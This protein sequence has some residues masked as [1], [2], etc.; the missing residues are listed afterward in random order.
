MSNIERNNVLLTCAGRRNYLVEFFK[1]ALDGKGKVVCTDCSLQAPAMAEADVA[2]KV[3]RVYEKNYV[4]TIL[5]ICKDN[6][7]GLVVSLN[8][9]DLPI[10]SERAAD[11]KNINVA[12]SVSKKSV[13]DICFDKIKTIEFLKSL[14]LKAPLTYTN[15]DSAKEAIQNGILKFPLVLKPRWGSGSI[16]LEFPQDMEELELSFN[17][18]K[19]KLSNTIL[20]QASSQ[21]W[22]NAIMIQERLPG[23]E[24][25][26][27][28]VNDFNSKNVAVFVK[29]KIRMRAGETDI[30]Q[31]VDIP[32]LVDIGKRISENLAHIGN[33]DCDIFYDGQDAYVLEMNP[34]FGGGYPFTQYAGANIPKAYIAWAKQ[35][36]PSID[37]F[38][39]NFGKTFSK[40][41]RLVEIK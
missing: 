23:E 38:N 19:K 30:A 18:L 15:F 17:L 28:V 13:I 26:L 16:G 3:P 36:S 29:R 25:G 20:K 31:S 32:T 12:L 24:Y 14:G 11:F 34:R 35:E 1:Q 10:L 22:Q 37:C 6:S 33:L 21:D 8:D 4:D 39:F 2:I 41:D 27:D 9:L 5:N 7:I 40:C